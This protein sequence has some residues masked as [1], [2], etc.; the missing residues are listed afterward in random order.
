MYKLKSKTLMKAMSVL[1]IVL[2]ALYLAFFVRK[3]LLLTGIIPTVTVFDAADGI[4]YCTQVCACAAIMLVVAINSLL[5]NVDGVEFLVVLLFVLEAI[6]IAFTLFT[7]PLNF[8]NLSLN[9]IGTVILGVWWYASRPDI[10]MQRG[11]APMSEFVRV[12]N[13]R[14]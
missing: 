4:G 10:V 11:A 9:A 8:V 12:G 3:V 14:G 7:N 2:S 1:L 6:W 5:D 13:R